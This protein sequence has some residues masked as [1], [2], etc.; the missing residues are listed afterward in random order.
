[1]QIDF[2]LLDD[3]TM[4]DEFC[5]QL[6][7][8]EDTT[9]KQEDFATQYLLSVVLGNIKAYEI[10]RAVKQAT[11]DATVAVNDKMTM[12]KSKGLGVSKNG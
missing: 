10:D 3:P 5:R 1:M 7:W 11:A 6:G 12:V 4:L 8:T 2:T 9:Q